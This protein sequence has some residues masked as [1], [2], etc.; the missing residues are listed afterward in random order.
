M[1]DLDTTDFYATRLPQLQ[2]IASERPHGARSRYM[3]GCRCLLCCAANS[4]Y[5]CQRR[6]KRKQGDIRDLVSAEPSRQ[7]L[8]ALSAKG[9]G[10]KSVAIACDVGHAALFKI[11]RGT[12]TQVRRNTER[13]I[14]NVDVGAGAGGMLIPAAPT[15]RI[16]RQ[17]LDRGYS[18]KQLAEWLGY[19]TKKIQ[20]DKDKITLANAVRVERIA[21]LIE[22]GKF[23]RTR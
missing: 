1:S 15:W 6:A 23:Q 12:K 16:I 14:L 10:Y 17:L 9:V 21:K 7:H 4:I 13:R 19:K 5:E 11:L 18:K 8:I 22:A 20:F 3:V 2:R